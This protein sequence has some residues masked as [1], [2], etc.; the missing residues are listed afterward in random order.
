[1]NNDLGNQRNEYD[2]DSKIREIEQA[3][4]KYEEKSREADARLS[5][6]DAAATTSFKRKIAAIV[7]VVVAASVTFVS[8][9]LAYYTATSTS[10]GNVIATGDFEMEYVDLVYPS[11]A[12]EGVPSTDLTEGVEAYPGEEIKK[13]VS[14]VNRSGMDVYVRVRIDSAITL[15][16]KYAHRSDEIDLSVIEYNIDRDNWL[17][18]DEFDGYYYYKTALPRKTT[19]PEFLKGVGFSKNMDN[20]Y[21]GATISV[22][23]TFE[24]VQATDNGETV[25]DAVGWPGDTEG[26]R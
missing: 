21:K 5:A 16:D 4:A 3:L 12:P 22:K 24:I 7:S 6:V 10:H 25:F 18:R 1:M 17:T 9:T 20:F 11:F 26:G 14:A 19:T 23:V 2:I 15:K 8:T 13:S